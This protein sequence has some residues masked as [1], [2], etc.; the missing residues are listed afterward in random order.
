[1]SI[2]RTEFL[3]KKIEKKR[4]NK[5]TVQNIEIPKSHSTLRAK[6]GTWT[7]VNLKMPIGPGQVVLEL[8]NSEVLDYVFDL[9]L[10]LFFY[11]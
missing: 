8:Q 6:R 7:K 9:V 5:K 10:H 2:S 11:S 4:Q 3:L 1:M